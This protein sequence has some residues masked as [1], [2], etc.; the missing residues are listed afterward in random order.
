MNVFALR[1]LYYTWLLLIKTSG[2]TIPE[3]MGSFNSCVTQAKMAVHE[4]LA[5]PI[6]DFEKM[7]MRCEAVLQE[8]K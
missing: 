6:L 3:L 2:K 5:V 4:L 8:L 1:Y 7:L